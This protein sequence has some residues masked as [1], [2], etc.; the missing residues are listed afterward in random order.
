MDVFTKCLEEIREHRIVTNGLLETIFEV[1][2]VSME[3]RIEIL[4][5]YVGKENFQQCE[6]KSKNQKELYKKLEDMVIAMKKYRPS[7]GV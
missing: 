1:N 2:N 7:M 3:L 5:K 6:S 4:K